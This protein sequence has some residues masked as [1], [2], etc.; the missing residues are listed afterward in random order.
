MT[1]EIK[2]AIVGGGAAAVCFL[3]SLM[4]AS[5]KKTWAIKVTLFD[6]SD[7][8]GVGLAYQNDLS[9]LLI[10][11]PAQ[12]MSAHATQ[13]DEFYHWTKKQQCMGVGNL[14]ELQANS[15]SATTQSYFSRKLFGLYLKDILN[16]T[17]VEARKKGIEVALIHQ[18]I[19]AIKSTHPYVLESSSKNTFVSDFLVL[20]TGNNHPKDV[21]DLKQ[22]PRYINNPYPMR[23]TIKAMNPAHRVGIIGNSLTAI[24][25]AISLRAS[26]H[27]GPIVM[28][29]RNTCYPRV[30]GKSIR[31]PL[32]FL[33]IPTLESLVKRKQQL[34]LR[35]L[36]RL[37]R[38]ELT[39]V[40]SD[41]R[42]LFKDDDSNVDFLSA[43]QTEIA[44]SEQERKW[45]SVLSAT[46][47]VIERC[48]HYLTPES[49]ALFMAKYNRIWLKNRSPIPKDNAKIL[50][51][52]TKE[53]Q[54][55]LRSSLRTLNYQQDEARYVAAFG[56]EAEQYLDCIV[57][58]TGPSKHL[59][60]EDPLLYG[61]MHQ[62]FARVNPFGGVEV[63]FETSSLLDANGRVNPQIRLIGH[64]TSGVH[65]YTSSLE[66][67][68]KRSHT[69]AL[70]VVE[71]INQMALEKRL[72]DHTP[73]SP[74]VTRLDTNIVP[75][76]P[77]NYPQ[78][79]DV[80]HEGREC[81]PVGESRV[82]CQ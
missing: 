72:A 13:L 18:T 42:L 6:A 29:S 39:A 4:D 57:N 28:M 1:Q 77:L 8:F 35:D 38:K 16:Q 25:V 36:L 19:V 65:Y 24:D 78:A 45:Q 34:T 70:S 79:T 14:S 69:V 40:H 11:R 20:C 54:L 52:M 37:L 53:G 59:Q 68:A 17:L 49:K 55:K 56:S 15:D 63:D 71:S 7:S 47:Q 10:N 66:M 82:S 3:R 51:N 46:N 81:S 12:T 61:M 32:A 2:V 67:I 58:A 74:I 22:T 27:Y 30:R 26:G 48:W 21:Y 33:N 23:D 44:A 43:M 50:V 73:R 31:Y 75:F 62:G 5:F 60:P 76:V 80:T 9:N 64:N 41:W